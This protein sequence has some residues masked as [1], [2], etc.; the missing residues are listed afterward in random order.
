MYRTQHRPLRLLLVEDNPAD[1]RLLRAALAQGP[2]KYEMHVVTDGEQALRFLWPDLRSNAALPRPDLVLLD[3]N[4]PR[5]SGH[6]VLRRIK[7]DPHLR[8]VPVIVLTSSQLPAD[9]LAAYSHG[10]N[11]YLPK[12]TSLDETLDLVR[13]LEHF[14]LD[15]A[16]LPA[17]PQGRGASPADP[18]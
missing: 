13:T 11:S 14:W 15:L 3:L 10:A 6:E 9:I 4:L 16:L 18:F 7:E 17:P 2:A 1:V 12:P 8:T 5:F